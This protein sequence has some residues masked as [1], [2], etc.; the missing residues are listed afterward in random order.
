[1]SQSK[2]Y[3]FRTTQ[4]K[5]IWSADI[6][7]RASAKNTVVTKTKVGF[8]TEAE[9]KQWAEQE[10]VTFTEKQNAQNK[11]RAEKRK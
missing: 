6:I 10:L 8:K 7:R 5:D 1:M 4:S 3:D 11:R 2:K 9:A